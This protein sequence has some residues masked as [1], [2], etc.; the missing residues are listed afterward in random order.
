[1][2]R[3]PEVSRRKVEAAFPWV[4][5][6]PSEAMAEFMAIINNYRAAAEIY[7]RKPPA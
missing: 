3:R 6:L 7:A 2:S 5:F 4:R 1:M